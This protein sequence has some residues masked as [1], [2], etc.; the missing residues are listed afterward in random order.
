M[1]I[2]LNEPVQRKF[3]FL[4]RGHHYAYKGVPMDVI[5][6]KEGQ[7]RNDLAP[8]QIEHGDA[9]WLLDKTKGK[10]EDGDGLDWIEVSPSKAVAVAKETDK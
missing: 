4:A 9:L 10:A 5:T 1:K 2:I 3:G 8:N 7:S 6:L